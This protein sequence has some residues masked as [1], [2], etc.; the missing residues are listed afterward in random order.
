MNAREQ[1]IAL[2]QLQGG[3]GLHGMRQ[4][5]AVG[6]SMWTEVVVASGDE[7]WDGTRS[8]GD[9]VILLCC[10]RTMSGQAPEGLPECFPAEGLKRKG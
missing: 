5:Q 2:A 7:A 8:C 1:T 3:V 6:H 9:R 4:R 10:G